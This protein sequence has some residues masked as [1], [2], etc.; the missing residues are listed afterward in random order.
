V[1]KR[2]EQAPTISAAASVF[3]KSILRFKP[4]WKGLSFPSQSADKARIRR[5]TGVIAQD[6]QFDDGKLPKKS[7][8]A[9]KKWFC[10][11]FGSCTY[12]D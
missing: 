3:A 11:S 10:L 2:N 5:S 4:E 8:L 7:R 6:R 12:S 1:T 9:G